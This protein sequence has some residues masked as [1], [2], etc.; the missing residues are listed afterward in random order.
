MWHTWF[1]YGRGIAQC[2]NE[3]SEIQAKQSFASKDVNV[4]KKLVRLFVKINHEILLNIKNGEISLKEA[5]AFPL[6]GLVNDI[7]FHVGKQYQEYR[8][9]KQKPK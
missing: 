1:T 6:M 5:V 7:C 3:H 2:L 4:F 9:S 8:L